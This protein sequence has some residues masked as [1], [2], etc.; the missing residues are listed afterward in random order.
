MR[1][2]KLFFST[3]VMSMMLSSTVLA[4]TWQSNSI[5]WWYQNDDGSY[6]TSAWQNIEGKNYLFDANGYMRTGW[7]QT[8]SGRWYYLNPT[9]EMRFEQLVENGITYYFDSDGYC[10]NPNGAL[11]FDSD[12]QSILD[13]EML[14][15][16]KRLLD[17]GTPA[18]NAYEENIVY[19]HDAAPQPT[20][21]RSSLADMQF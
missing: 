16:Q 4:G 2:A 15:A 12:Y 9:G 14:D 3:L 11:N 7:I 19:E 17:Q 5:G 1:R 20:E 6:T 10:T 18:G 8:V 13:Q 21:N